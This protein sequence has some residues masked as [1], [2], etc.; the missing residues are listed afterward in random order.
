MTTH[1]TT[2]A[3]ESADAARIRAILTCPDGLAM[4][5]L[6]NHIALK[7]DFTFEEALAAFQAARQD[8]LAEAAPNSPRWN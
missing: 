1:D 6:A 4:P 3:P 5:K 2:A 8:A 7:S